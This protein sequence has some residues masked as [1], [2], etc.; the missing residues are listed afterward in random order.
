MCL[1]CF[2]AFDLSDAGLS[3]LKV[4]LSSPRSGDLSLSDILSMVTGIGPWTNFSSIAAN[5]KS[6][7][8]AMGVPR[9]RNHWRLVYHAPLRDEMTQ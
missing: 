7:I 8:A 4:A 1:E 5:G 2:D 6:L 9:S 3:G